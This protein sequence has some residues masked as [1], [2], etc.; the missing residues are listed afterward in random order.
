MSV[1][2]EAFSE[3]IT[4]GALESSQTVTLD[5]GTKDNPV[6][7]RFRLDPIYRALDVKYWS[8]D[9]QDI[10]PDLKTKQEN[11]EQAYLRYGEIHG[12]DLTGES[13]L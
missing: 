9:D 8:D 13:L 5:I 1:D 3:S 6:P 10:V 2:I 4:E 12:V 7:L 11:I